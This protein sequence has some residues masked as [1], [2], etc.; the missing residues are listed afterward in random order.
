MERSLRRDECRPSTSNN[1]IT[2]E[3]AIIMARIQGPA[4]TGTLTSD[5]TDIKEILVDLA[6]GALLGA[7]GEQE[8][9]TEVLV[10]LASAIPNHGDEAEV[11]PAVYTRI[12]EATTNIAKLR[13][14]EMVLEKQLEVV[15]ETRAQCV[16]N[17]E[18]DIGAIAAKAEEM[19]QRNKKPALLAHFE[20]TIH[21]RSQA[22]LKALATRKKNEAAAQEGTNGTGTP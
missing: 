15:R 17:R 8:G 11:H 3:G 14:K 22:G 9:L 1:Q 2:P 12:V 6:P 19:A 10:E 5:L 13:E 21:Y 18:D 16:N 4:Y 20:K 7:R